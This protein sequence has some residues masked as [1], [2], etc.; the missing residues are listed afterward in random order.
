MYIYICLYIYKYCISVCIYWIRSYFL[1]HIYTHIHVSTL[2]IGFRKENGMTRSQADA[3][4]ML[5]RSWQALPGT[6]F[7]GVLIIRNLGYYPPFSETPKAGFG[8]AVPKAN[9]PALKSGFLV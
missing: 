5:L 9:I 7:L 1:Y 3:K 8:V 2:R 4:I 6:K